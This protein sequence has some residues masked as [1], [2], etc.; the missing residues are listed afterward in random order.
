M[1]SNNYF[2]R[3]ISI[4]LLELFTQVFDVAQRWLAKQAR[5]LTIEL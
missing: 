1:L 3:A 4:L 2:L 5:V